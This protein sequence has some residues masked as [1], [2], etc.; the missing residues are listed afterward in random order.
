MY[1]PSSYKHSSRGF[2]RIMGT[3]YKNNRFLKKIGQFQ[4]Q[5]QMAFDRLETADYTADYTLWKMLQNRKAGGFKFERRRKILGNVV[6]FYCKEARLAV[7]LKHSGH[8]IR[9][10]EEMEVDR[11]L[12]QAGIRV[13]R[14]RR[15]TVLERPESVKNSILEELA[16]VSSNK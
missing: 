16:Q 5:D 7:D 12:A 14:F 4:K 15:E 10:K 3:W 13:L 2:K 11:L 6:S 9:R 1:S 8:K